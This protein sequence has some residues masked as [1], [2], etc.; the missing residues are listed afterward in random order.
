MPLTLQVYTLNCGNS[1][2]GQEVAKSLVEDL[3][4]SDT[5]L[6][7]L[8][9]QEVD[10]N[11]AM[12]DL[13]KAIGTTDLVV[14]KGPRMATHTKFSTQFHKDTGMMSIVLHKP[15]VSV[16]FDDK[17]SGHARR[18]GERIRGGSGY[19]K[20][21]MLTRIKAT[22][23]QETYSIDAVNGHLDAFSDAQRAQDWAN[24]HGLQKFNVTNWTELCGVIPHLSCSGLDMN[25][26]N[27]MSQDSHGTIQSENA[28]DHLSNPDMQG[29]AMAPLGNHHQSR[30]STY[31]NIEGVDVLNRADKKRVGRAKGGMLDVVSHTD[32]DAAKTQLASST[33]AVVELDGSIIQPVAGAARDHSVIGSSEITLDPRQDEVERV[34]DAIVCALVDAAP[35][36]AKHLLSD[37]FTSD[38]PDNQKAYLLKAYQLYLSPNGLLQRHLQLHADKLGYLAQFE[39]SLPADAPPK[40]LADFKQ[41]LFSEAPWLAIRK[42]ES[43]GSLADL[44]QAASIH[45]ALLKLDELKSKYLCA[46]GSEE[47]RNIAAQI[48]TNS[49]KH[50][51]E[52]DDLPRLGTWIGQ[53]EKLLAFNQTLQIYERYLPK[54]PEGRGHDAQQELPA[55]EQLLLEKREIISDFNMALTQD[56][57]PSQILASLHETLNSEEKTSKL[58]KHRDDSLLYELWR[59]LKALVSKDGA[60]SKGGQFARDAKEQLSRAEDTELAPG[61]IEYR[62]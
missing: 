34:R 11:E 5:D 33:S 8:N 37:A 46:A 20:G 12:E 36:L 24:V 61:N 56:Q 35:E 19:N 10:F 23:G 52:A 17:V 47:E 21:G 9:C 1:T 62:Q 41:Q 59:K 60:L 49:V 40:L 25:T 3:A 44:E 26:R 54:A 57:E 7:I 43:L 27:I 42:P 38:S 13:Q 51:L 45:S 53:T 15:E 6:F 58:E 48:I 50:L 28:W 29:F 39:K 14:S 30:P 2:P 55:S 4:N 31:L 16:E 18:D 22:K 32:I